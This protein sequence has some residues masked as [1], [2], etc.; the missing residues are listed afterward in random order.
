MSTHKKIKKDNKSKNRKVSK[1]RVPKI[2]RRN[3]DNDQSSSFTFIQKENPYIPALDNIFFK[4]TYKNG[5]KQINSFNDFVDYTHEIFSKFQPTN[6]INYNYY[7]K[8]CFP[9]VPGL[10]TKI[11]NKSN[12]VLD[13]Y[14]ITSNNSSNEYRA[15][16]YIF[17]EKFCYEAIILCHKKE[18]QLGF[19]D[20][21]RLKLH[22]LNNQYNIREG[23]LGKDKYSYIIDL[24]TMTALHNEVTQL[25]L[26]IGTNLM[27]IQKGDVIGICID[28]SRDKGNIDL[29]ING[30][31]IPFIFKELPKGENIAY[32]PCMSLAKESKIKINFG[33]DMP[34]IYGEQ[35]SKDGYVNLDFEDNIEKVTKLEDITIDLINILE[36]NG[37]DLLNS[38][39]LNEISKSIIFDEL[40]YFFS[41]K[42][43][44]NKY[45]FR[46]HV[47]PFF[48]K[49]QKKIIPFIKALLHFCSLKKHSIIKRI[50][51]LISEEVFL[52]QFSNKYQSGD[53]LELFFYLIKDPFIRDLWYIGENYVNNLHNIFSYLFVLPKYINNNYGNIIE[54]IND[55]IK[56]LNRTKETSFYKLYT[57]IKKQYY[58]KQELFSTNKHFI[59]FKEFIRYLYV[60]EDHKLQ[61]IVTHYS[62]SIKDCEL[63]SSKKINFIN[64]FFF[65]LLN[66]FNDMYSELSLNK[67]KNNNE[68]IL[69]INA[70]IKETNKIYLNEERL[71]GTYTT[72]YKTFSNQIEKY[73]LYLQEEETIIDKIFQDIVMYYNTNIRQ[74]FLS[75]Q[76]FITSCSFLHENIHLYVNYSPNIKAQRMRRVVNTYDLMNMF[77]NTSYSLILNKFSYNITA[78]YKKLIS[79]K[80]IYFLPIPLFWIP[81]D[82][83]QLCYKSI[84]YSKHYNTNY[85]S[86]ESVFNL[87][88]NLIEDP[89]ISHPEVIELIYL[90]LYVF[91]DRK[92]FWNIIT[93]NNFYLEKYLIASYYYV[94][95]LHEH[96]INHMHLIERILERKNTT[97]EVQVFK[98]KTHIF[99]KISEVVNNEINSKLTKISRLCDEIKQLDHYM[100]YDIKIAKELISNLKQDTKIFSYTLTFLPEI[101]SKDVNTNILFK[102]LLNFLVNISNRILDKKKDFILFN[103][104]ILKK[105]KHLLT[106]MSEFFI[107]IINI[108]K[109][110]K[111]KFPDNSSPFIQGLLKHNQDL[112]LM[113]YS[114]IIQLNNLNKLNI[115]QDVICE[116]DKIIKDMI[117]CTKKMKIKT[118]YTEKDWEDVDKNDNICII[119]YE[120]DISHHFKPCGH[121][122]CFCCLKQY[123]FSQNKCFLCNQKI[124]GVKEGGIEINQINHDLK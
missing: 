9:E 81:F 103:D 122:C 35:Y 13:S 77:F 20:M 104:K 17:N 96:E 66:V 53:Y 110:I 2:N 89:N 57:L 101:L 26:D 37:L 62:K 78:F 113:N 67:S 95:Q 1:N 39:E 92:K 31:K 80:I 87:L 27:P 73:S 99:E 46:K 118:F 117:E 60:S 109:D 41:R 98:N 47:L 112:C 36:T 25:H 123:L 7:Y 100:K 86:I 28:L 90:T 70:F 52:T 65:P 18:I 21:K 107:D 114:Y 75:L 42:I 43:I 10:P 88:F 93:K 71:S 83:I 15:N 44:T 120:N 4:I 45:L 121:G 8:G 84:C 5:S 11:I 23:Y 115:K 51:N 108:F 54:I 94:N 79:N 34:L 97:N 72:I 40:I 58:N 6:N 111:K 14:I 19:A 116:F 16:K 24:N 29:Y 106:T 12:K 50:L 55:N 102:F 56:K 69:S 68:F 49:N 33:N 59:L 91:S 3:N 32:Y 64:C 119:C 74:V 38:D 48:S 22:Y 63:N 61:N 124:E 30:N 82:F 85:E 105:D 76:T